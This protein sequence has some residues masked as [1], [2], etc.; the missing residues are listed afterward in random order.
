MFHV[1]LVC[2]LS[3]IQ[4]EYVEEGEKLGAL[5]KHLNEITDGLILV[6]VETKRSADSLEYGA[7][8]PMCLLRMRRPIG[9]MR[10]PVVAPICFPRVRRPLD[11][12]VSPCAPIG[13]MR[14]PMRAHWSCARR[15]YELSRDGYPATSIHGDRTQHEREEALKSFKMGRTPILVATDVASRGLDISNVTHVINFDMPSSID[16]YVHRIGRTGRVG[17]TGIAISFL[18]DKNRAIAKEL[19]DLMSENGQE[20]P[21]WLL[22]MSSRGGSF[23]GGFRGGRGGGRGGS[24]F[25]GRDY[26]REGAGGGGGGGG[27]D[28]GGRDGG[29]GGGRGGGGRDGGGRDGGGGARG[30]YRQDSSAW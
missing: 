1:G 7:R 30:G 14:T 25:G 22:S 26:R 6:F 15:R 9:H 24:R 16:D 3:V 21:S 20:I 29:G 11:I 27:R 28:G 4:V 18:C 17:N 2:F 5:V 19:H 8:A 13:H 12:C 23:G 10:I